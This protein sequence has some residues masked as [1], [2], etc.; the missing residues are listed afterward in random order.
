MYFF[1]YSC[2]FVY[3]LA[4]SP[5]LSISISLY[6]LELLGEYKHSRCKGQRTALGVGPLLPCSR[7]GL[8]FVFV[9]LFLHCA[10]QFAE[11][12]QLSWLVSF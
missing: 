8:L 5:S 7:H 12:T 6:V 9:V 10:P 4:F 3:A 1:I 2:V 11:C